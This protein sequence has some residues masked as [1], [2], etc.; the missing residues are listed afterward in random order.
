MTPGDQFPNSSLTFPG[1]SVGIQVGNKLRTASRCSQRNALTPTVGEFPWER[2]TC[3]HLL[4]PL[5][6]NLWTLWQNNDQ[7]LDRRRVCSFRR[8]Q[9]K[10][11]DKLKWRDS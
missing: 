11:L 2:C 9:S 10:S 7:R 8:R 1:R 5:S 6:P 4:E 3:N